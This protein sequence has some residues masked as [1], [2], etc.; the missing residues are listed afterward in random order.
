MLGF[1]LSV[2]WFVVEARSLARSL[3]DS[4]R[5][6]A[7][8]R[9]LI[10]LSYRSMHSGVLEIHVFLVSLSYEQADSFGTPD[11]HA[12]E[13]KRL[14]K[15]IEVRFCREKNERDNRLSL[16]QDLRKVIRQSSSSPPNPTGNMAEQ[17]KAL[18]DALDVRSC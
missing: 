11:E 6:L 7:R 17:N 14:E 15:I 3:L 12:A 9:Q 16:V 13:I 18:R 10:A 8:H 4:I 2:L 1:L 5:Y